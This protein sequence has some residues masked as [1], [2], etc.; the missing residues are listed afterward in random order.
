M[1]KLKI[2]LESTVFNWYFEPERDRHGETLL[3]FEEI[4]AGKFE[5]FTSVYVIEELSN[6]PNQSKRNKMLELISQ[7]GITILGESDEA[8]TLA[9]EYAK[10]GVITQ[11]HTL[12]RLHVACATVNGLDVIISYN[13]THINRLKTKTMIPHANKLHGYDS[14]S[15]C[16]PMEVIGNDE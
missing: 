11:A 5:A 2:Y 10:L 7:Y 3:L 12:D 6:T 16:I 1:R 9:D 8:A 14:I 4:A 15:I 13:F